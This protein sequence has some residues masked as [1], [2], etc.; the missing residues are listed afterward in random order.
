MMVGAGFLGFMA[1]VLPIPAL[2]SLV[3][4]SAMQKFAGAVLRNVWPP[5]QVRLGL[6]LSGHAS[7]LLQRGFQV[8]DDLSGDHVRR[9]QAVDVFQAIILQPKDIEV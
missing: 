7:K 8:L 1:F 9:R 3:A 5:C 2:A 4:A 6:Q